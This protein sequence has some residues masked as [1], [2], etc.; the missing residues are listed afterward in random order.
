MRTFFFFNLAFFFL[1]ALD[2]CHSLC[3]TA[4]WWGSLWSPPSVSCY[5]TVP[6]VVT[7]G[8]EPSELNGKHICIPRRGVN[9]NGEERRRWQARN[10]CLRELIAEGGWP[11]QTQISR[12]FERPEWALTTRSAFSSHGEET[13]HRQLQRMKTRMR[14]LQR[15]RIRHISLFNAKMGLF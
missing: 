3:W 4:A 5:W 1:P 6:Q 10:S 8:V 2:M 15:I 11:G 14:G 9:C 7:R 12:V 13:R